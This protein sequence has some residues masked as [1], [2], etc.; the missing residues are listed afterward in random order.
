LDI[1][2]L[3][4]KNVIALLQAG[5]IKDSADIFTINKEDLLKLERF[6][7]ISADKLVNAI[8][9][10]KNPPLDRFVY[11][12]G[13]RQIGTQTA[14]DIANYFHA[15]D[16]LQEATIDELSEI[17]GIGEVVAES[18]VEWFARP[19]NKKLLAKFSNNGV[20]PQTAHPPEG[21]LTGVSIVVTGSLDSMSREEAA[22]R[23]RAKGGKF[24]SSV[25][26]ETDYLVVGG[27]VGESKLKRARELGTK[28]I[29]E[30]E[31][32]KMLDRK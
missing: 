8:Q 23:I 21:P 5:L 32:L 6:A 22:E 24:Q 27:S 4:E 9:S 17:E 20:R 13:I 14:I 26:Q 31:L 10:K 7:D 30:V 1:D 12:L 2:G 28:Q 29:D 25:S 3:G 18:V 15:F 16:K 19:I 11:G